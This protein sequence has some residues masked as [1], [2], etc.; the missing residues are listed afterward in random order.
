MI[1]DKFIQITF[2]KH[3]MYEFGSAL[4]FHHLVD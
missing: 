2:K 4:P 3:E 1:Y